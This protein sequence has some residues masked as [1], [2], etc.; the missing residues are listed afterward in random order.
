MGVTPFSRVGVRNYAGRVAAPTLLWFAFS[1]A[2]STSTDA[3]HALVEIAPELPLVALAGLVC[4][5][6]HPGRDVATPEAEGELRAERDRA[7]ERRIRDRDD[8]R[9]D[10]ELL[11]EHEDRDRHDDDG[12]GRRADLPT[13]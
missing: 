11:Q 3:L 13:R 6:Q 2:A 8:L 7:P 5:L 1:F 10:L 12:H 4:A 9:R